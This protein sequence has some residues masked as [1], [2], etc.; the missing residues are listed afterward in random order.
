MLTHSPNSR[1]KAFQ[2][3]LLPVKAKCSLLMWNGHTQPTK[4][5]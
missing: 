3:T 1:H 2:Q 5:V 4:N